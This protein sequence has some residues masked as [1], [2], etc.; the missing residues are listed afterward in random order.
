MNSNL[1]YLFARRS[2]RAY[3]AEDIEESLVCDLLEATLSAVARDP[4]EFVVIRNR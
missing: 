2:I 1:D 3:Q 4:W